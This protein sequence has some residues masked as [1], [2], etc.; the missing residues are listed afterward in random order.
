MST[1]SF[2][3]LQV[4]ELTDGSFTRQIVHR[5][6]ADLPEHPVLIRVHWSSLNYKDALS[7]AGNKGVTRKYPHTPGIDAAGIVESSLDER[8]QPG[9]QVIV[10]SHDLGMNTAGGLAEYIRV[11][12]DWIVPLPAGM[13]LRQSMVLGTAGLTAGMA[14]YKLERNG[15][16][17]EAGPL[18]V[19]GA[20]GGVGSLAVALLAQAGYDVLAVTGR[21][22]H[23]A[24]LQALG[25]KQCLSREEVTDTS[26]RPLLR[27]R[28]AGAIDTVGGPIL[29]TLMRACAKEGNIAICGLV[30]SPEFAA[31][32]FPF[33]LNGIH[34]LGIDSAECPQTLRQQIWQKLA[35]DW[36]LDLA[37]RDLISE[38]ALEE[39]PAALQTLLAGQGR[40]R[41]IVRLQ[42]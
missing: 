8:F 21:P 38:L 23:H 39:V 41:Q 14:L 36:Q 6:L 42:T 22:E 31:T 15:Q 7:A 2:R 24:W 30:A 34:L 20:S 4:S 17:P 12:G 10:T 32:V 25:A 37:D 16:R 9:D 18:V 33:I 1:S 19:T 5:E 29:A 27:S 28:W 11:P 3:A 26:T 35:G 13:S 40:G